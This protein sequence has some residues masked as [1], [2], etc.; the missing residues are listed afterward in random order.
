ML[1]SGNQG[2]NA[3]FAGKSHQDSLAFIVKIVER[4]DR[5]GFVDAPALK[6]LDTDIP[7]SKMNRMFFQIDH[8]STAPFRR[9]P[10]CIITENRKEDKHSYRLFDDHSLTDSS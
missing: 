4:E 3:L 8:P 9:L 6:N 10:D 7:G 2:I 5:N 1:Q